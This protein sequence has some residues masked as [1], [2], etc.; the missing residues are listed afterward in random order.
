M[1]KDTTI[2][3]TSATATYETADGKSVTAV[4]EVTFEP[5]VA[6]ETTSHNPDEK[7]FGRMSWSATSAAEPMATMTKL[8]RLPAMINR[9]INPVMLAA[10]SML[11]LGAAPQPS[12]PTDLW[13]VRRDPPDRRRIR[14]YWSRCSAT[15]TYDG[16]GEWRDDRFGEVFEFDIPPGEPLDWVPSPHTN[17]STM[18]SR[19]HF[20]AGCERVEI[21]TDDA[22]ETPAPMTVRIPTGTIAYDEAPFSNR[23]VPDHGYVEVRVELSPEDAA[24]VQRERTTLS[25][26]YTLAE[27]E[28]PRLPAAPLYDIRQH[29][30]RVDYVALMPDGSTATVV[31]GRVVCQCEPANLSPVELSR[32]A[33]VRAVPRGGKIV[34]LDPFE[35]AVVKH[36]PALSHRI[37]RSDQRSN[38]KRRAARKR[39]RGWA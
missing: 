13:P 11:S 24:K 9:R 19:V 20:W 16:N 6:A 36:W 21:I 28:D 1:T 4:G 30:I 12:P 3:S 32:L 34:R 22:T 2:R 10:L 23:D 15:A 27:V 25:A 5:S 37:Y 35:S 38:R 17:L 18:L 31:G 39:K 33:D 14:G 26:G 7:V 29:P 8:T